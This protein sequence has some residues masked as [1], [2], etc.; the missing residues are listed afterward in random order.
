M[1]PPRKTLLLAAVAALLVLASFAPSASASSS[2]YFIP[3]AGEPQFGCSQL[4]VPLDR[5]GAVGGT[6]SLS[7]ERKLAGATPSSTALLMLAGGPGQAALPFTEYVAK[8]MAP[9]LRGRDLLV[10][11]Q[12]G[13]GTS[14]PLNCPALEQPSLSSQTSLIA[15]CA[16]QIGPAR[17]G[18]TTQESVADIEALREAAGYQ[19]LILYGTSYGTK[20][21]LEYA[22]RYPQ[23]VEA[24]V[25]D[26]VVPVD[27]PEPFYIP[28][29]EAVP[30]V[31][32]Q[33]CSGSECAGIT[34]NAL[35]DLTELTARLRKRPLSG[36]VYD[37]SGHRHN[38]TM[39]ETGLFDV[40]MAGDLNPALRALLPAA[41]RSA[42]TGYPDPLLRLQALSEGLVPS[43]PEGGEQ[44]GG[45]E[46]AL[47]WTTTC[48]EDPFPW[49]RAA[50]GA[51][52]ESEALAYLH[53]QPASDFG[54]FDAA[55]A[56]S[57]GTVEPC[58]AWPDA[59]PAPPAAAP[60]PNVPTLIFSGGQDLRTPTANAS[61]V[62]AEIPDAQVEVVPFTG[63]SVIGSDLTGCAAK[64]LEAFFGGAPVVPCSATHEPL[65]PTP[66]TPRSLSGVHTPSGLRGRPGR[67]L[68]AVLDTLVDLNEQVIAAT[69][70]VDSQLPS[71]ASFGGLHG[72]YARLT[73]TKAVLKN[74]SFVPGVWLNATFAVSHGALATSTIRVSGKDAAAGEV[75]VGADSTRVTGTLGGERF[76]LSLAKVK[77]ASAGSGEWPTL[78][79]VLSRL[80][81]V[82]G[83]ARSLQDG[84]AQLP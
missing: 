75:R 73:S 19:K 42:L 60:L 29:F 13:T 78:P 37:G 28:S 10:F 33:L 81:R 21:A 64:A 30:S 26:S 68:V 71:G 39:N 47:F 72:G 63:H 53:S 6:I 49:N 11:D 61:A 38:S 57:I 62:A 18:F 41:I 84:F 43:L 79:L 83:H 32:D 76:D 46:E 2:L 24:L 48:E 16:T 17:G 7:V 35:G 82:G 5:S 67:T 22:E 50:S 36:S 58:S 9:A 3:C 20:V 14:D 31:I 34:N 25:L 80:G 40:L 65:H 66:V 69:L 77:L 4:A 52:R 45:D 23:N 27:G 1:P 15:Q 12:R 51:T 8:T 59:S 54:P 44:A 55:T 70:Q 56:L 74:L